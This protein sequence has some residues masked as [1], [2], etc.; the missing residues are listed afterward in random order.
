VAVEKRH[1][2]KIKNIEDKIENLGC[3]HHFYRIENRNDDDRYGRRYVIRIK[4]CKVCG[5]T[6]IYNEWP[7]VKDAR[8]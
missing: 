8:N 7:K 4:R 2:R 6:D 1:A 5:A 3:E